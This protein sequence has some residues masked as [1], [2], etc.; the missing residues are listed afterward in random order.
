MPTPGGYA[1]ILD[2]AIVAKKLTC[3]FSHVL[4]DGGSNINI[5]YIDTMTK[6]DIEA[7]QLEPTRIVFHGIMLGIS[8]SAIGQIWPDIL[9]DTND[10]F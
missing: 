1:L 6:L 4:I 5:L 9:F 7:G 2:H 10:H 8:R 3:H